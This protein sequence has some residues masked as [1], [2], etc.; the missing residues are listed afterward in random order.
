MKCAGCSAPVLGGALSFC[1]KLRLR[2]EVDFPAADITG[3]KCSC[4]CRCRC[5]WSLTDKLFGIN[6]ETECLGLSVFCGSV[7]SQ[8]W[9]IDPCRSCPGDQ[10]GKN[11]S[12]SN[13]QTGIKLTGCALGITFPKRIRNS[14][15]GRGELLF[16]LVLVTLGF[17]ILGLVCKSTRR[18]RWG[19]LG[20]GQMSLWEGCWGGRKDRSRRFWNGSRI[21]QYFE[22]VVWA[23]GVT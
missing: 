18:S 21:V 13:C 15:S 10:L 1:C 7:V 6:S 17:L 22:P 4:S 8:S 2:N 20:C 12:V 9:I 23:L 19:S 16:Q 14:D 11:T 3:W 5:S